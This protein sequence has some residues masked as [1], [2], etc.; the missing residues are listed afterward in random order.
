VEQ[1]WVLAPRTLRLNRNPDARLLPE[2]AYCEVY[3]RENISTQ[4]RH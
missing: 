4:G 1:P 2:R 3:E